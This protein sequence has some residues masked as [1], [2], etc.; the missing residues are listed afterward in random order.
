MQS[1]T[2]DVESGRDAAALCTNMLESPQLRWAFIRKVYAIILAQLLLTA[3][4]ASA[5]F[6]TKPMRHFVAKTK[7]GFAIYIVVLVL[8]LILIC[9]LRENHKR[10]PLN[11]VLLGLFTVTMAFGLGFSCAFMKEKIIL[12]AAI[13]TSV[14]IVAL[15]LYTFWA[16][17]R[18]RDF[19][20]LGPFLF[21]SLLVILVFAL[22]QIFFPLGKLPLMIF[23]C[24]V[25][26]IFAGFIVYDTNNLIK[27]FS[28]DEYIWA[29]VS[30]YLDIINLFLGL[31]YAFGAGE[32]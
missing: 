11:F 4:V 17:K 3:G 29:A 18:G 2:G 6:L 24:L 7:L 26:I 14:V 12:E 19:S 28:Y 20:F 1:K 23:G 21:A 9:P 25:S 32:G 22:V 30:L 27:R 16:V 5:I 15:T 31:L 13:L 8:P 10:H